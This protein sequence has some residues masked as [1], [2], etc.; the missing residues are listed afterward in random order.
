MLGA[1]RQG[2]FL[3]RRDQGHQG[4]PGDR[5]PSGW[6]GMSNV[7]FHHKRML[8]LDDDDDVYDA[9]SFEQANIKLG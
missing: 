8:I 7:M 9:A 4:G 1:R 6:R 2:R 5:H 3:A